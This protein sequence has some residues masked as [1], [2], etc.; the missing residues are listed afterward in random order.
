MAHGA[1]VP[2]VSAVVSAAGLLRH[3]SYHDRP[4]A[5][6][7]L[8]ACGFIGYE[9]EDSGWGTLIGSQAYYWYNGN[10]GPSS[11]YG[12]PGI[13]VLVFDAGNV[14]AGPQSSTLFNTNIDSN[15]ASQLISHVSAQPAGK[16]VVL[17]CFDECTLRLGNGRSYI[18]SICG[19]AINDL[20]YRGSYICAFTVG[21]G[22]HYAAVDNHK[23]LFAEVR[24]FHA[25]CSRNRAR[26]AHSCVCVSSVR[27]SHLTRDR[28]PVLELCVIL[29]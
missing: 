12:N 10:A 25:V 6:L 29:L 3:D 16:L 28:M 26:R 11:A 15:V 17:M 18:A 2:R 5:S 20:E 23:C 24:T 14:G 13:R 22:V 21:E 8:L 9:L 4:T 7:R 1:T 19:N 27:G